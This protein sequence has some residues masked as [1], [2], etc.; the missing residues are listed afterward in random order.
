MDR[1]ELA[2]IFNEI[3]VLLELKGENPFKARAYYNAARTMEKMEEDLEVLIQEK[4]LREVSGFGEAIVEKILEWKQT[5]T[6]GY[7]DRL[8]QDTPGGL[9]ELL[10]LPGLGPKKIAVLYSKLGISD[11]EVLE[12][13][14]AKNRLLALPG[15][16]QKTQER[17]CAGIQFLREQRGCFLWAEGMRWAVKIRELLAAREGTD[18]KPFAVEIAGSLR[19]SQPVCK[20]IDLVAASSLSHEVMAYFIGPAFNRDLGSAVEE[21]TENGE[22]KSSLRLVNGMN[23]DLRVVK[24]EEYPYAL[25]HFT[26]GKEHNSALRH[27][28]KDLGYKVNEYGLFQGQEL[29]SCRGETEIYQ[30]LGLTYIPPELREDLGEIEAAAAGKLPRL[31]ETGDIQGIFHVHTTYSDGVNSLREMVET[32]IER[33]YKYLGVADHSQTAVY[34]HGMNH[35]AVKK[36]CAEID[37]LN[38]EYKDF[39]IFKGIEADILPS[40]DLDYDFETLAKFDFVIGSVHSHFWMEGAQMTKRI[41]RAMENPYLTMVGHPTGRILLGRPAYEVD[42]EAVIAKAAQKGIIIELNANP[43]RLDLDWR[44]CL[45]AKKQGV[46]ISINPDAHSVLELDLTRSGIVFAR[47]GWLEKA[48]IFNTRS[49]QEITDFFGKP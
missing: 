39:T 20:D 7:Y 26:G 37:R 17:I 35:D 33:G 8:R 24:P 3:G 9:L 14:C 11:L 25:L 42:L 48:D 16:G 29:V 45:R 47:K 1:H 2:R 38:R 44:W 19:R 13:A 28:V 31:V 15:F 10:R 12:A 27:L 22:T 5:G 4:R 34:A 46:L 6:I 30:R 49:V 21:I 36:Q 23:V 41:L 43:H 32:A 18:G 40:G